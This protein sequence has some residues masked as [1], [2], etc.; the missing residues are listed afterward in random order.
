MSNK[1]NFKIVLLGEG[2]VGKTSLTLRFIKEVFD[3]NQQSTIQATYLQKDIKIGDQNVCLS[4]WDT[5]G[6]EV[7]LID[8]RFLSDDINLFVGWSFGIIITNNNNNNLF[9]IGWIL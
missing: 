7:G 1:K 3:D 4:V 2:R 5:A 9:I 8:P 6:Q